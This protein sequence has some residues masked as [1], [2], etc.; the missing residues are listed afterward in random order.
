MSECMAEDEVW[1]QYVKTKKTDPMYVGEYPTN[2]QWAYLGR[3]DG[4]YRLIFIQYWFKRVNITLFRE[5]DIFDWDMSAGNWVPVSDSGW[6]I[7]AL[8]TISEPDQDQ[9]R[10]E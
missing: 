2:S 3:K 10:P 1:R 4:R 7:F 8:D 9:K 5:T 6:E